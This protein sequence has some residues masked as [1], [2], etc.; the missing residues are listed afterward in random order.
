MRAAILTRARRIEV[1]EV[2][3]PE[4]EPG[5]VRLRVRYCGICGSD[6]LLFMTG[7]L[8]G[9]TTVLGHEI[10]AIVDRDPEGRF[11]PGTRV[12]PYPAV[13]CGSC[14]WCRDGRPSFCLSPPRQR[15][16]GGLAEFVCYPRGNLIPVPDDLEDRV[17][18][19]AEPLGVALR[20][21]ERSGARGGELAY[22]SG[23]GS[24]G[25]LVVAALAERGCRVVGADPREERR[26]LARD[27]GC[28]IA[29][30]PTAEDP[31]EVAF[32]LDPRGPRLAFE[33]A[34][35][36]DSLRWVFEVCGPDGT[37]GVLG[38]P[39]APVLL[40]RMTVREQRAFSISGPSPASMRRALDLLRARPEVA[41]VIT[42]TVPLEAAGEALAA[43]AAGYGG[44]KVL[45]APG[46]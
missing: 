28:E 31:A 25:L 39:T 40:L 8:A 4:P 37:V 14:L 1:Q 36:P 45:V 22:V 7:A 43:L 26:R 12:V 5:Q 16:T 30:D 3:T 27:L 33:C 6:K 42:G 10:S 24:I 17:A 35:V 44:I 34:G 46:G 9:L 23:L 32:G 19:L 29:L 13:G 41:R 21:V 2:P 38:V 18:A 15:W 11:A 20:A